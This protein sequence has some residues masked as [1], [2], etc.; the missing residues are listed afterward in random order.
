MLYGRYGNAWNFSSIIRW[1]QVTLDLN[2]SSDDPCWS[3]QDCSLKCYQLYPSINHSQVVRN[4]SHISSSSL[5]LLLL[6][7][8]LT[9]LSCILYRFNE[10]RGCDMLRG[11]FIRLWG[12]H[13]GY[14]QPHSVLVFGSW[15]HPQEG[16]AAGKQSGGKQGREYFFVV[17]CKTNCLS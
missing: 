15:P 10:I 9:Q 7:L 12:V 17:V 6:F 5:S 8:L 13:G 16:Y 2:D 11:I 4:S 14:G 3:Q 1:H